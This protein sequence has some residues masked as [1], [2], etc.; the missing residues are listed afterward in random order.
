MPAPFTIDPVLTGLVIAYQN[1]AYIA[2]RVLPRLEPV[3]SRSEFKYSAY[4]FGEAVSLISTK[5]GRKGTPNE[6]EVTLTDTPSATEDFALDDVV[7]QDDI[8]QAPAAYDP[9]AA[10]AVRVRDQ[11]ML[12]REQRAAGLV[13]NAAT[14]GAA[15]KVTLSGTSQWSDAT[16]NPIKAIGDAR[17]QMVMPPNILVLGQL[18]WTGLRRNPAIV[19]SISFSGTSNGMASIRAVADLL[20]LDDIVVGTA[21][22]NSAR[23][24]QTASL[25][26]VWG[27]H[28]ALLRLDRNANAKGDVPTFGFTAQYGRPVAGTIPEP[29]VGLRGATRVRSGES[30]KE[31]ICAADLGYFFQNAVA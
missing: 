19:S 7:P 23:R 11:I 21:W 16:S 5:V 14:Y 8:D 26:R 12:D 25:G 31:V 30:V 27:K 20:E 22:I 13:F 9:V 18:A 1:G 4:N 15:N 29:K 2:D 10:A 24:G 17:D 28:A 6:I 3:L